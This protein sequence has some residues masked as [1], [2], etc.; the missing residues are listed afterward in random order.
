MIDYH[1]NRGRLNCKFW[2]YEYSHIVGFSDDGYHQANLLTAAEKRL[3]AE[4]RNR[5]VDDGDVTEEMFNEL[6]VDPGEANKTYAW[7]NK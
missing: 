2:F 3:L 4:E 1:C 5:K 7:E 6:Y